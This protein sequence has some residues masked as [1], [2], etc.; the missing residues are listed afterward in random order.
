MVSGAAYPNSAITAAQVPIRVVNKDPTD[1]RQMVTTIHDATFTDILP[2]LDSTATSKVDA[3]F[4]FAEL[5]PFLDPGGTKEALCQIAAASGSP[6]ETC[7]FSGEPYCM[8]FEAVQV[9][10]QETSASIKRISSSDI[11]YP[12]PSQP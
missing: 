7:P 1:P 2:G 3:V 11:P 12:C 4:D 10:T 6:C 5:A 9:S 8:S